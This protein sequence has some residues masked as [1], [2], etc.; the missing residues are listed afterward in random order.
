MTSGDFFPHQ[1]NKAGVLPTITGAVSANGPEPMSVKGSLAEVVIDYFKNVVGLRCCLLKGAERKP[2][3]H[4]ESV[5]IPH[6]QQQR[7]AV[8]KSFSDNV[9]AIIKMHPEECT[10]LRTQFGIIEGKQKKPL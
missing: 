5:H 2:L 4:V 3:L 7:L 9:D 10:S 1:R 6:E 8:T